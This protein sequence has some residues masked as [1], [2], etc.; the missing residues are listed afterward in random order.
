MKTASEIRSALD[1]I[2]YY[3]QRIKEL[4]REQFNFD[5]EYFDMSEEQT[6]KRLNSIAIISS[7]TN[8][9]DL[10]CDNIIANIKITEEFD[11]KLP[12]AKTNQEEIE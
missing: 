2:K 4:A 9:I 3:S 6:D 8:W 10:Y 12:I 11:S 1:N 7:T 5:L